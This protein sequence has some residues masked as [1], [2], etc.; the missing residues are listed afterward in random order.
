MN[1]KGFAFVLEYNVSKNK[2]DQLTGC[3]S[4]Y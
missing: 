1:A 3:Q 2:L 4:C